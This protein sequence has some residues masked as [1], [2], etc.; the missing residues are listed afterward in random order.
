MLWRKTFIRAARLKKGHFS[1]AIL[2][3]CPLHHKRMKDTKPQKIQPTQRCPLPTMN[4]FSRPLCKHSNVAFGLQVCCCWCPVRGAIS[5]QLQPCFNSL[6]DTLRTTTPLLNKV[7]IAW[8]VES[9]VYSRLSDSDRAV[10]AA[11]GFTKPRGPGYGVGLAFALFV[12]QGMYPQHP[13]HFLINTHLRQE[14]A[15]LVRIQRNLKKI[16]NA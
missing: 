14:S 6:T 4:H 2:R 5:S 3:R 10:A 16:V 13:S 11:A 9:Y 1:S 15:S 8:L 12:M 7:L